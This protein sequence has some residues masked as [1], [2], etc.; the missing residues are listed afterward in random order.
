MLYEVYVTKYNVD[1]LAPYTKGENM[2]ISFSDRNCFYCFNSN[3]IES[4]YYDIS[5][6]YFNIKFKDKSVVKSFIFNSPDE[7][8]NIYKEIERQLREG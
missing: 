4:V 6:S 3:I 2:F 7:C 1:E 5:D 8:F